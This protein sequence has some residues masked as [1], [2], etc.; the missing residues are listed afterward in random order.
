MVHAEPLLNVHVGVG[1]DLEVFCVS[2]LGAA[3]EGGIGDVPCESALLSMGES[4]PRHVP[5]QHAAWDFSGAGG[6][7]CGELVCG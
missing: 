6:D 2:S 7:E 1:L 4:V 3:A 5:L